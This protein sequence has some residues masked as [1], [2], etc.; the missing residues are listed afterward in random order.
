[1]RDVGATPTPDFIENLGFPDDNPPNAAL[2]VEDGGNVNVAVVELFNPRHD[3]ATRTATYDVVALAAYERSAAGGFS[4]APVDLSAVPSTFEAAH[5][6]IDDCAD[7]YIHCFDDLGYGKRS[8][9][10]A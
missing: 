3:Q 6:F 4:E 7:Q 10:T 9:R 2:L 8:A 5:L 1:M